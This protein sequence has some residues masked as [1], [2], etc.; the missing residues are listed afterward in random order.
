MDISVTSLL[1]KLLE[2]LV[3]GAE[4]VLIVLEMIRMW[5]VVG[6]R[7]RDGAPGLW[8]RGGGGG[9]LSAELNV[10]LGC[11]DGKGAVRIEEDQGVW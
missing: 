4:V 7:G 6:T 5:V 9:W 10:V 2:I 3:V 1:I 8:I 11:H